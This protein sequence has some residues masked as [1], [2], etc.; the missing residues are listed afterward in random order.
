MCT[1]E[2]MRLPA[3]AVETNVIHTLLRTQRLLIARLGHVLTPC[4]MSWAGYEILQTLHPRA[5]RP[6]S[7]LALSRHLERHWTTIGNTVSGLERSG[8][9]VRYPNP[10]YRREN[11]VDLTDRGRTAYEKATTMLTTA[12]T[13]WVPRP[14]ARQLLNDLRSLELAL[15]QV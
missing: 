8:H 5:G 1:D 2:D 3:G 7:V 11:I 13:E 4:G 12:A 14:Q 9:V 10:K 6:M 15:R